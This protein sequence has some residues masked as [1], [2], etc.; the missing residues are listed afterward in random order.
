MKVPSGI[1]AIDTMVGLPSRDRTTWRRPMLGMLRDQESR[2]S[3]DH[4]ASYMYRDL[5]DTSDVQDEAAYLI[6]AMDRVGVDR[7][8]IPVTFEEGDVARRLLADHPDRFSGTYYLDPND[9]M[10]ATRSLE[11]AVAELGVVAA[12][13]FPCGTVPPVPLNDKRMYPVYAKCVDLGLPICVNTGIPGPRVPMAPQ[14]VELLDEVCWAFPELTVVMRHGG[15]PWFDLVA[16]LLRKWPNLHYSTSAYAPHRY[17]PQIMALAGGRARE[18]LIYAGYFPS[19]LTL[20]TIFE[21]FDDLDLDE[22]AWRLFLR[23]NAARVFGFDADA[24][25]A[26]VT[27]TRP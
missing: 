19:G 15:S 6:E 1:G 8:L 21:Q 25:P 16:Q 20:D 4:A 18:K 7:A 2:S 22:E 10:E 11:R 17:P 24:P 27:P 5:P 3:F 12:V 14:H 13:A 9:G 23:G 26:A